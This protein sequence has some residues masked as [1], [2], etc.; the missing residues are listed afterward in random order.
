M[1][2]EEFDNKVNEMLEK[3]G[4]DSANLI[5]DDVGILL[6]DNVEMNKTLD[7]KEREIQDLKKTNDTLQKV[8]GNLLQQVSMHEDKKDEKPTN[9][10]SDKVKDN[11][12]PII[13]FK[14]SLDKNGNFII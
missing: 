8:N 4:T 2:K 11:G 13:N 5:L 7:K 10:N 14:D 3:I 9:L 6:N 12:R 1:K